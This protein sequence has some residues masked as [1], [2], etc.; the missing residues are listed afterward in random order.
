MSYA[1]SFEEENI[2]QHAELKAVLQ[3]KHAAVQL[4]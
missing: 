1:N 3:D 4:I 2:N